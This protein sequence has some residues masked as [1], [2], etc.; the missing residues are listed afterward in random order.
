MAPESDPMTPGFGIGQPVR[1]TEDPTLLRGA[2]RYTDDIALDGQAYAAMVRSPHAHGILKA[3]DTAE[4]LAMPG[5]LAVYTG[6]DLAAAGY[7]GLKCP[8]IP[9]DRH[10]KP[11]LAPRRPA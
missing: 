4:A 11:M 6:A 1:R 10:G 9:P 3:V 5:V 8:I 7:G 2:G